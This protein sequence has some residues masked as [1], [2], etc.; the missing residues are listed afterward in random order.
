M[1]SVKVSRRSSNCGYLLS[2]SRAARRRLR[3]ITGTMSA[4]AMAN[5]S[6]RN[7]NTRAP[8]TLEL[9]KANLLATSTATTVR[10]RA[11]AVVIG[12]AA[13]SAPVNAAAAR[14][15]PNTRTSDPKVSCR[16]FVHRKMFISQKRLGNRQRQRRQHYVPPQ[17]KR[18]SA[19]CLRLSLRRRSPAGCILPQIQGL[20][21]GRGQVDSRRSAFTATSS[22]RPLG[23]RIS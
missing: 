11:A 12:G 3:R 21:G 1:R 17:R 14:W 8:T 2:A 16:L 20:R 5:A 4:A 13:A 6:P 22:L 9:E 15:R 23:R 10:T 7:R 18:F 19:H